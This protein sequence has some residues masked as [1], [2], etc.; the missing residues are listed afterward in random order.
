MKAALRANEQDVLS[1][2]DYIVF[3]EKAGLYR[4][5]APAPENDPRVLRAYYDLVRKEYPQ[6]GEG[7][8]RLYLGKYGFYRDWI[9]DE[10]AGM[11]WAMSTPLVDIQM[12]FSWPEFQTDLPALRDAVLADR[13]DKVLTDSFTFTDGFGDLSGRT[14][15]IVRLNSPYADIS[16][17]F[18]SYLD[19]LTSERR[20]K[21]RRAASDF[22]QTN[23][24]FEVTNEGLSAAEMDIIRENIAI[25]W[26]SEAGYSFRQFLWAMAVQKVRP[27]QLLLL[28]VKDGDKTVFWQ[29]MIVKGESIYCQSIA[30]DE[31][32][33]YNG[34]AAFADLKCV[35]ALCSKK[36]RIFDPSCRTGFDDPESIGIAKRA[37]VN[38][39]CVKPLLVIGDNF[40]PG[41]EEIVRDYPCLGK[42]A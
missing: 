27:E 28:R 23:L 14:E 17:N 36:H 37:T 1:I 40:M 39:N 32:I 33:F 2:D 7:E 5:D 29:T 41:V 13:A 38:K 30:K 12:P 42:E 21:Y 9:D 35:E 15:N 11:N 19:S 16:M 20:K 3:Q 18:E 26:E 34:L 24:R 31:T 22:E 8:V 25:K 10:R 4:N 6:D